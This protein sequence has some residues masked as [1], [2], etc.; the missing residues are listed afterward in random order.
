MAEIDYPSKPTK[1]HHH[2]TSK[3]LWIQHP[4]LRFKQIHIWDNVSEDKP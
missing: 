1:Y 2:H 4:E 3:A